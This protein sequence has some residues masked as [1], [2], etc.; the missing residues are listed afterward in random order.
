MFRQALHVYLARCQ[1]YVIQWFNRYSAEN[2]TQRMYCLV[3]V[4]LLI[5]TRYEVEK[6]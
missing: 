6:R 4:L 2:Y 1:T 3:V 5:K